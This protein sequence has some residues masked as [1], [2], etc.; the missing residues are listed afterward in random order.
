MTRT[1]HIAEGD[2]LLLFDDPFEL[3]FETNN[4]VRCSGFLFPKRLNIELQPLQLHFRITS[5]FFLVRDQAFQL[6]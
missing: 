6:L 2:V 4:G 5:F 1:P 3:L